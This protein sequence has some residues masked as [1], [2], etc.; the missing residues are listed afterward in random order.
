MI[1]HFVFEFFS[2]SFFQFFFFLD[3]FCS[4]FL[5]VSAQIAL[6]QYNTYIL[7]LYTSIIHVYR[8]GSYCGEDQVTE[9]IHNDH[10]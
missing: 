8:A 6:F 2:I 1:F 7:A 3:L 5:P 9:G 10:K 4:Q